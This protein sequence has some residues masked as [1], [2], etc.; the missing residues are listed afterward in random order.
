M[1]CRPFVGRFTAL[2][3]RLTNRMVGR[4]GAYLRVCPAVV[5]HRECADKMIRPMNFAKA[6]T[7]MSITH[8]DSTLQVIFV[9]KALFFQ[10]KANRKDETGILRAPSWRRNLRITAGQ[11][12]QRHMGQNRVTIPSQSL[13]NCMI[14][15][16]RFQ[17]VSQYSIH[18]CTV[19]SDYFQVLWS[20]L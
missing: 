14:S 18:Q 1:P 19:H 20:A 7:L 4:I 17:E 11:Q 3:G 2:Y 13:L 16:Y 10:I 8:M 12:K 5:S 9:M 6:F 15:T